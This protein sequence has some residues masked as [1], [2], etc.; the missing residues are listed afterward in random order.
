MSTKQ[1]RAVLSIKDKQI[2][3]SRLDK[4]EKGT[5]L[6]Q[7]FGISKQQK[8]GSR[9][10]CKCLMILATVVGDLT[11]SESVCS[12]EEDVSKNACSGWNHRTILTLCS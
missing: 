4:G 9:L 3:I 12:D 8:T 2:I 6:A 1:K 10:Q 5:D 11:E 7:E